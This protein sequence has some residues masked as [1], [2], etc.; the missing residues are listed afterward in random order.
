M[1]A[2]R[3]DRAERTT[4]GHPR[5]PSAHSVKEV[6]PG[7]EASATSV[8]LKLVVDGRRLRDASH[9]LGHD[10]G[11][12]VATRFRHARHPGANVM[13]QR[14]IGNSAGTQTGVRSKNS[15]H[16]REGCTCHRVDACL[17]PGPRP[18]TAPSR[19][20]RAGMTAAERACRT[21]KN[22]RSRVSTFLRTPTETNLWCRGSSIT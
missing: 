2:S 20:F 13:R 3:R 8:A 14:D 1:A 22:R 19:C 9:R 21:Q 17:G 5:Q 7:L 11:V 6:P 10:V 4:G 12:L 18:E 16:I 15:D